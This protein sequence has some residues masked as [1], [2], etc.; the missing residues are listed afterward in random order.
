[1]EYNTEVVRDEAAEAIKAAKGT[2]D[3]PEL[4]EGQRFEVSGPGTSWGEQCRGV[5]RITELGPP[6]WCTRDRLPVS[7]GVVL[8]GES[9]QSFHGPGRGRRVVASAAE[10]EFRARRTVASTEFPEDFEWTSVGI[11]YVARDLL[12]VERAKKAREERIKAAVGVYP[13][14]RLGEATK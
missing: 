2:M 6:Q 13:P 1:M 12:A 5:L 14:K 3:L 8:T 4:P 11:A 10:V 9:R 7:E